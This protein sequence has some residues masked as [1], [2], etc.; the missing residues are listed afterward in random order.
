MSRLKMCSIP[1]VDRQHKRRYKLLVALLLAVITCA[2]GSP[3]PS[4]AVI[5]PFTPS[6]I[7][8]DEEFNDAA[9]MSCDAIQAFLNERPGT[10]KGYSDEGKLAAQIFCA[11]ATLFMVN[12]RIL[13][14]LAQ[15]EMRLLTDPEP[16]DKQLAWALGC[17]PG[18]DSTR[19]L[20]NQVECAARTLRR[21]FDNASLG[22]VI[23]GVTPVNRGTLALYHYTTHVW[24][25]EDFHKIWTR[26]WPDSAGASAPTP[27]IG[28][29]VSAPA[30]APATTDNLP[31]VAAPPSAPIFVDSRSTETVPPVRAN[32]TCRS[33]WAIGSQGLG[34]HQFVTPNTASAAESTNWAIWR[35]PLPLAGLYRVS[36][37]VPDRAPVVWACGKLPAMLDTTNAA[38]EVHHLNGITII[39]VNQAPLSD[40][41]VELGSFYFSADATGYVK[42]SDVTGEPSNTRWVSFDDIKFEWIQP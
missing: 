11:Q 4:H 9:A 38:Y 39:P 16:D 17:G 37:F 3:S 14:T 35:P 2:S 28:G 29:P 27:S 34:G 23:D 10:L 33:G 18:W 21:R 1:P 6:F 40:V 13:L 41:W 32:T 8:T 30:A 5:Q 22:E 25:N 19:G 31:I 12:P 36:V 7:L 42:L 26:Y 15:K 24:G 20:A